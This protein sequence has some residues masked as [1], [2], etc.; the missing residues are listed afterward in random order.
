ML[1]ASIQPALALDSASERNFEQELLVRTRWQG[2]MMLVSAS[3]SAAGALFRSEAHTA[4]WDVV[5]GEVEAE[6]ASDPSRRT[7]LPRRR[8]VRR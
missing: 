4:Q 6:P 8:V 7:W 3:A 1:E 2:W 5:L